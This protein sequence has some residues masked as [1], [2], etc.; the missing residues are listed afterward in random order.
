MGQFI[1]PIPRAD[2]GGEDVKHCAF[3]TQH[4][5]EIDVVL[6]KKLVSSVVHFNLPTRLS[7]NL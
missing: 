7:L 2:L 3:P 6:Q 5:T 4:D 1:L